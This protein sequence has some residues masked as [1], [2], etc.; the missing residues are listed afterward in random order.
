MDS[1]NSFEQLNYWYSSIKQSIEG[2]NHILAIVGN[3]MDLKNSMVVS[4][5]ES[6]KYAENKNAIFKL[7]SAKEDPKGINKLFDKLL[8]E[9][10]QIN[11]ESMTQSYIIRKKNIKKKKKQKGC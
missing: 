3:K 5:E 4:E 6:R 10:S 9:L 7:V 2:E 11:F 8:E 1:L